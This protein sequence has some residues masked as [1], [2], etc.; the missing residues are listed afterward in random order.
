MSLGPILSGRVPTSLISTRARS[1]VNQ[2]T[3]YLQQLSDQIATGQRYQLP[4]EAP[5][6]AIRSIVLQ[7]SLERNEQLQS[8]IQTDR[9]FLGATEN[10]LADTG[11]LYDELKSLV[12]TG[13]G[14][15]ITTS[16]KLALAEQV[17]S[18]LKSALN[19]ANANFR[20]RYLF[21]GSETREQ[22]FELVGNGVRYNGNFEGI[23]SYVG[24]DQLMINNADVD[25]AFNPFAQV[26]SGDLNPALTLSTRIEDLLGGEG[27]ELGTIAVTVNTG[28]GDV[29]ENVDL[30][31]SQNLADIKTRIE[32]AFPGDITVDIDP[33][34]NHGLRLTPSAGTVAVADS[35]ASKV[36]A[37]LGIESSAVA[38][39]T[40]G[41]LRPTISLQTTLTSLNGGTGIGTTTGTGLQITIDST[42][43]TIDLSTATTIEDLFNELQ[44][45]GLDLA[46]GI[47]EAGDGIYVAS[48]ISGVDFSIGENGGTNATSLGIRTLTGSTSLAELNR[49]LGALTDGTIDLDITRR[50]GTDIS[51]DITG[52]QTIQDVIDAINAIDAG[53]LVASLNTTGNGISLT[54]NS[55]TGPLV[56]AENGLST[57]LGL[58]GAE[59]GT[60][61]SVPLV[62][63]DVNQQRTEGLFDLILRVED[64]LRNGDN[65][66]LSKIDELIQREQTS[67]L[68]VRGDVG[69]RLRILDDVEESLITDEL[70][71]QESLSKELDADL[72]ETITNLASAQT[73]LQAI[74]QVTAS[75]LQLTLLNFL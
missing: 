46:Y 44:G 74:Q 64:G 75:T 60:D 49:G 35:T 51:V 19:S 39:I 3:R 55:G 69:S 12:L 20:G 70:Q 52:A 63:R 37:N 1:Q 56:V 65:R 61:N 48:R 50:D 36:A 31:G 2:Q 29:T 7:K 67:A 54:D 72:A 16:E 14:D 33:T 25:G 71:I 15:N 66:S 57:A 10:A 21:G 26:E 43:Q 27:I 13:S 41:D 38:Q 17:G 23:Q 53:N 59:N 11:F 34:T 5:A 45:S 40:G 62:G 47:N 42:T 18:L 6:A 24:I 8:N 58:D 30:S 28:G 22:P 9:S 73:A 68:L 4:S 32:A